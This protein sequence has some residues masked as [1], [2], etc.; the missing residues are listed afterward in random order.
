[1]RDEDR[2]FSYDSIAAQY[3]ANV[4]TAPFNAFYERPAMM[5]L[6]PPVA[7]RRILDAGCGAGWYAEQLLAR[8]ATVD[9]IDGSAAM[10]EHARA[11]LDALPEDTRS[12]I[13]VQVADL[14]GPLPFEDGVFDGAVSPLVL[15]YLIDW[16][17][18]LREIHRVLVPGGWYLFSTHHPSADVKLFGTDDYFAT[19]LVR[20]HWDWAGEVEFHRRSLT[21]IFASIADAGLVVEKLVEP[22]PT[23]EFR[24]RD[25]EA[26]TQL[27]QHPAFIVIKSTRPK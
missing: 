20:D 25:S 14:A 27:L 5:S 9:A 13:T 2:R 11:R 10:V 15:H 23:E 26:Y 1:M 19:E 3:A 17:P 4:D 24:E 21:E 12:R 22:R 18:A 16:R 6:L 7:G 8:G